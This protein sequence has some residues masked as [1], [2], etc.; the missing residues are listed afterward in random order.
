MV[1]KITNVK[2]KLDLEIKKKEEELRELRNR[3]SGIAEEVKIVWDDGSFTSERADSISFD[4]KKINIGY[5]SKITVIPLKKIKKIVFS[6][7]LLESKSNWNWNFK[8]YGDST[9]DNDLSIPCVWWT[10]STN[11]RIKSTSYSTQ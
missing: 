7:A 5:K 6:K 2:D 11:I 10:P 1:I 9:S 8:T 4:D 3:K